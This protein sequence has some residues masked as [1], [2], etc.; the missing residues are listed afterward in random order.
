MAGG[1]LQRVVWGVVP[2]FGVSHNRN[3]RE[4]VRFG[5]GRPDQQVKHYLLRP[6]RRLLA[7]SSAPTAGFLRSNSTHHINSEVLNAHLD[8][9]VNYVAFTTELCPLEDP[10]LN[11][12]F[13][14]PMR[15]RNILEKKLML[16][17]EEIR[18]LQEWTGLPCLEA[19]L[20]VEMLVRA[21]P[22]I[23][24]EFAQSDARKA[25]W[26]QDQAYFVGHTGP[27]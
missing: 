16:T 18:K 3:A 20:D 10:L 22:G 7:T 26:L 14:R 12:R 5:Y 17:R 21:R 23:G 25:W 24:M 15:L 1:E 8:L 9:L 27:G 4:L 19:R 2:C 11:L 13:F 6:Q